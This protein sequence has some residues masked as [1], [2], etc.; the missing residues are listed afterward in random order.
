MVAIRE[1][2]QLDGAGLVSGTPKVTFSCRA[3]SGGQVWCCHHSVASPIWNLESQDS[4]L[5]SFE[6]ALKHGVGWLLVPTAPLMLPGNRA[7]CLLVPAPM[8]RQGPHSALE[9]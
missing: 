6:L 1:E 5:N 9:A 3:K 2:G 4:W 7:P 8:G